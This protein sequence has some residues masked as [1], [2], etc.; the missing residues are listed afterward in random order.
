MQFKSLLIIG[1]LIAATAGSAQAIPHVDGSELA[2]PAAAE[3]NGGMALKRTGPY[4]EADRHLGQAGAHG[5]DQTPDTE[6]ALKAL[7][8]IGTAP[9]PRLRGERRPAGW[10]SAHEQK[11][12]PGFGDTLSSFTADWPRS[13]TQL[14]RR[15]LEMMDTAG[16]VTRRDNH[17]AAGIVNAESSSFLSILKTVFATVR[18][19]VTNTLSLL[20]GNGSGL[21]SV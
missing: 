4:E 5:L 6:A 8:D 15:K 3:D 12:Q 19:G 16:Q 17:S 10:F 13:K 20:R 1:S 9:D 2:R 18:S 14:H 11:P 7:A 21:A